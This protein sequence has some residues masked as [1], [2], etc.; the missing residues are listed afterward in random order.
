[1]FKS[2]SAQ[3]EHGGEVELGT[4]PSWRYV[5]LSIGNDDDAESVVFARINHPLCISREAFSSSLRSLFEEDLVGRNAP[6]GDRSRGGKT[7][8]RWK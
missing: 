7:R 1:M 6:S 8:M 3:G 5:F 4:S 2:T